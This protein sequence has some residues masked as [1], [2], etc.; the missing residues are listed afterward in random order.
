M[1]RKDSAE[2]ASSQ[3]GWMFAD[4]FLTLTVI[5][6]ATVSFIPSESNPISKN[7]KNPREISDSKDSTMLEKTNTSL[8]LISNGFVGTY[9]AKGVENFRLDIKNYMQTKGISDS[10]SALY[11]EVIG[12]TTEF[13]VPNDSGNLDALK[14]VIDARKAL[15]GILNGTNTSIN[16]SPDVFKGQVRVKITFS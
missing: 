16:L 13:N 3:A 9:S 5:F 12:N 6:L 7:Q 14:F 10:T 11:L 15:P 2:D 1:N 8:V 4:L